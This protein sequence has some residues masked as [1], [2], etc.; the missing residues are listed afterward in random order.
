MRAEMDEEGKIDLETASKAAVVGT[1][2]HMQEE[3]KKAAMRINDTL[4]KA[5][6]VAI[7]TKEEL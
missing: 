6:D 7:W 3:S 2:F 4:L 1:G 5:E